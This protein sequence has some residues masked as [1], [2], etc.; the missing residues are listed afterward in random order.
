[1]TFAVRA[2]MIPVLLP[3]AVRTRERQRIVRKIK[4]QIKELDRRFR[5]DP[6]TLTKRLKALHAEHGI[7]MV[8]WPGLVA[9]LVQVPLLIAMFQA[10]LTLR[11]SEALTASGIAT[12]LAAAALSTF[13]TRVSGQAEGASW[14]LW[15]SAIL[16]LAI[17]LWLGA[18]IGF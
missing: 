14:M 10:V 9:A 3:L 11:P 1:A 18:G 13:G 12:G 8:D 5:D 2:L 15:M 4:P 7:S 6:G 17:C 16:P